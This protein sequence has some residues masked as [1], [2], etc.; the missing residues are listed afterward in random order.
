MT[1]LCLTGSAAAALNA[2][3]TSWSAERVQLDARNLL[4]TELL[5]LK[6]ND[7]YKKKKLRNILHLA[8]HNLLKLMPTIENVVW[9]FYFLFIYFF[10]QIMLP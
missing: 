5:A 10:L 7:N 9:L 3:V 4:K 1:G 2:C 6:E 8:F